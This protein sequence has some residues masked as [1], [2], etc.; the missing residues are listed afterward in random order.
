MGGMIG[1]WSMAEKL[2]ERLLPICHGLIE[3]PSLSMASN[4]GAHLRHRFAA[5]WPQAQCA[6]VAASASAAAA[7]CPAVAPSWR[8]PGRQQK[9][10]GRVK[11]RGPAF[12]DRLQ[13]F[14]ETLV[15]S[16]GVIERIDTED[17]EV[18]RFGTIGQA[19]EAW[20][21]GGNLGHQVRLIIE[22]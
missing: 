11:A 13:A 4:S 16:A 8:L 7:Q 17:S 18:P 10:A 22:Y 15:E 9:T 1:L 5:A 3:P 12:K 14:V 21:Y 2:S 19:D 20:R 6:V